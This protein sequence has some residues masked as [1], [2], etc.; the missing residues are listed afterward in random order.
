MHKPWQAITLLELLVGLCLL[1]VIILALNSI[2]IFSHFQVIDTTRMIMLQKELSMS[3]DHMSKWIA[4][5][6]GSNET[7]DRP[8]S[9]LLNGTGFTVSVD[10]AG[11][12]W[13]FNDDA[14]FNYTASNGVLTCT[15]AGSTSCPFTS[16]VLATHLLGGVTV[17]NAPANIPDIPGDN[18]TVGFYAMYRKN[19][20]MNCIDVELIARPFPN[21]AVSYDNKQIYM[22]SKICTH[23]SA[24]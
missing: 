4:Q 7:S 1:S 16:K 2:D 15:C 11:T 24:L 12:P 13:D 8:M 20:E 23:G 19:I 9:L 18:Q 3:I 5:A 17:G 22:R 14:L 21:R 10:L 6:T